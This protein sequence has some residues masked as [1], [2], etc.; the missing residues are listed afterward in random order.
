MFISYFIL[1]DLDASENDIFYH[2]SNIQTILTV[3]GQCI[4][5]IYCGFQQN[6]KLNM[7][8]RCQMFGIKYSKKINSYFMNKMYLKLSTH[9][10]NIFSKLRSVKLDFLFSGKSS[11]NISQTILWIKSFKSFYFVVCVL[12]LYLLTLL[13]W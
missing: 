11:Y 13:E 8:I 9:S 1:K 2:I 4:N 12:S 10:L 7:N 3:F 6:N 5:W